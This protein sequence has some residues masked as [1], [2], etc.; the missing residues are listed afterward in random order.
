[1]PYKLHRCE[2][3]FIQGFK[4]IDRTSDN[5]KLCLQIAG[6]ILKECEPH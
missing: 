6:E 2:K 1:M 5:A 4:L 3:D